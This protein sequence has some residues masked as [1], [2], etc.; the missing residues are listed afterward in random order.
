VES[1]VAARTIAALIACTACGATARVDERAI[2]RNRHPNGAAHDA[3]VA[4]A[5]KH[6]EARFDIAE[7]RAA[8]AAWK[9][10]VALEDDDVASYLGLAH[11][12]YYLA[13]TFLGG[14]EE[15]DVF[16]E[17]ASF[18]DRG[19]RALN[20]DFELRR[21]AG[22]SVPQAALG[23]NVK[24]AA[25]LLFFWGLD[26]IRWADLK[27]WSTAAGVYKDVFAAIQMADRLDETIEHGGPARFFG[28]A[29]AE[30]PAIAGGSLDESKT[31]FDRAVKIDPNWL[32]TR[33]EIAKYYA[34]KAGDQQLFEDSIKFVHDAPD[35]G[36]PEQKIAKR[37]AGELAPWSPSP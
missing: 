25:P 24:T 19:L 5:E 33:Y 2:Q 36:V 29:R 35:D 14:Q 20:K 37:R 22:A 30:A 1:Q 34:R 6:W 23:V 10:A 11:G 18:A 13:D 16:E 9:K 12:D 15:I 28:A 8:I 26:E 3:L 27:G 32:E 31:Y 7:A 4:E 21:N 17:G